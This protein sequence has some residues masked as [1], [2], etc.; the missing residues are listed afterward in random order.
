LGTPLRTTKGA[1]RTIVK[2]QV[3][4]CGYAFFI[5]KFRANAVAVADT[6]NGIV[7]RSHLW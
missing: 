1:R 2:D 4:A 6:I 7:V 3:G 5:A